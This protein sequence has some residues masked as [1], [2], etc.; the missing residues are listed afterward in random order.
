ML[1]ARHGKGEVLP[2][3]NQEPNWSVKHHTVERKSYGDWKP[4][5]TPEES[6]NNQSRSGSSDKLPHIAELDGRDLANVVDT[7]LPML[8]LS[9]VEAAGYTMA[10]TIN[11]IFRGYVP[12][13]PILSADEND[14]MIRLIRVASHAQDVFG[15]PEKAWRWLRKPKKAFDGKT[16]IDM[17]STEQG[18]REVDNMLTRID[19][20][21]AA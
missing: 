5:P 4:V 7:G 1:F 20:G 10:E 13:T 9:Q 16:C 12:S 21:M 8:V 3:N 6:F 14:R 19:H 15:S 18:G 2:G 11:L 17:L